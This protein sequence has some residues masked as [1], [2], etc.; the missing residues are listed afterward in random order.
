MTRRGWGVGIVGAFVCLV[1]AACGGD[2]EPV[3]TPSPSVTPTEVAATVSPSPSPTPSPSATA[4]TEEEVLAAIPEDAR[5]EDY[6]SSVAFAEFFLANYQNWADEDPQLFSA[7]SEPSCAFCAN[8]VDQY[9][10]ANAAGESYEGGG[11]VADIGSARG[12][13]QLNGTWGVEMLIDVGPVVRRSSGG[14]LVD[15]SPGGAGEVRMV[16]AFSGHWRVL[17]VVATRS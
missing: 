15:E 4:L 7:L 9:E 11:V 8:V 16:M 12:G 14:T 5:Y 10:A 1:V 17:E 13:V 2:P 6:P 3:V